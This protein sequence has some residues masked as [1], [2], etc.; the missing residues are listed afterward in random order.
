MREVERGR[1]RQNGEVHVGSCRILQD[2][3]GD[4]WGIMQDHCGIIGRSCRTVQNYARIGGSSWILLDYVG[5]CRIMENHI[6]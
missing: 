3:L 4:N 5:V 1:D 6:G 2:H